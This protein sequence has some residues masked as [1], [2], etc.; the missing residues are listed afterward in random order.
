MVLQTSA[1]EGVSEARRGPPLVAILGPTGVGK[2]ALALELAE[3]VN[4]E[5]VSVDSRQVYRGLEIGTAQ[6]SAEERSRV[7]HHLVGVLEPGQPFSAALFVELADLALR[8]I[9]ERGRVALLVGGTYHY[10]EALLDRLALPRVAPNWTLRAELESLGLEALQARL[11]ARDPEAAGAVQAGN[12]RRLIRAIEVVEASG[13]P[14]GEVGR[15]RGSPRAALRLALSMPRTELYARVDARVE[16]M[17]A[18]GWLEEVRKLLEA[19]YSPTLPALT[20]TGYREL[21]RHLRGEL[22]LDEATRLVKYSTHAFIRRQYAW[23][24][25]DDRLVWIE[26]GP[27][28]LT[29]AL[30]QVRAHL[31]TGAGA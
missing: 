20:S 3:A 22:S 15:S 4:G 14:L 2:S 30:D 5:I 25:R 10:L 17:L 8:E 18:A 29:Q 1:G 24:R 11:A 21:I 9:A 27:R 16:A 19:G 7:R 6:P 23:L 13:R 26:Q 12:R 28:A 31:A